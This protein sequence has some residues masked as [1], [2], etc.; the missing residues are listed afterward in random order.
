MEFKH[1]QF[2]E[3][4]P[5]D[6]NVLLRTAASGQQASYLARSGSPGGGVVL[7]GIWVSRPHSSEILFLEV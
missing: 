3:S 1:Q 6:S 5:S 7:V 4:V 2:F